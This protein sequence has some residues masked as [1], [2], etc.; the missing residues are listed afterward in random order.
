MRAG[1]ALHEDAMKDGVL[2][3]ADPVL[4]GQVGPTDSRV[5]ATYGD[6]PQV[7]C[8]F[9]D[10]IRCFCPH[11]LFPPWQGHGADA[12]A[13]DDTDAPDA[14]STSTGFL[15]GPKRASMAPVRHSLSTSGGR[16][17][18]QRSLERT[19]YVDRFAVD[20]CLAVLPVDVGTKKPFTK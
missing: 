1:V 18:V 13:P 6:M 11:G 19:A 14:A 10:E 17:Y 20:P 8:G 3:V 15:S 4:V 12:F 5:R 9:P 16:S 7:A 2:W